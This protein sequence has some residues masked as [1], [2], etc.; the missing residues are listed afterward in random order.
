VPWVDEN[1]C[2]GCGV[3]VDNC[4][5]GALSLVEGIAKM[6]IATCIRCGVCHD[7]CPQN[8]VKH[9]S[10]HVPIDVELNVAKTK[11]AMARDFFDSEEKRQ[12]CLQRWVNFFNYQK[13]VAEQTLEALEA[14]KQ[15]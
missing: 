4:P 3:C 5:A 14:L 8:A 1:D 12:G 15:G 11:E 6:D 9:D 7:V 10:L 2:I 13:N